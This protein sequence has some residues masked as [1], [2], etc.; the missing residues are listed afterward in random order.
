MPPPIG[1]MCRAT[2][3][4]D[5]AACMDAPL[6]D[7]AH[8][9]ATLI[10]SRR[11]VLPKRLTGPEPA[12]VEKALILQAASAAP[13]HHRLQPWRWIEVP[14]ERRADLGE[15]FAAALRLRDPGASAC[16]EAQAR[17]KALR[18]P[19]LLLTV[20]RCA[21]AG[22]DVPDTERLLSAGAAIQNML[23]QATAL[24][25]ASSITSGKALNSRPLRS[26]FDLNDQ[27]QVL[28]FINIGR[29]AEPRPMRVRPDVASFYSVLGDGALASSQHLLDHKRPP[30]TALRV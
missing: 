29:C 4:C 13:D 27:E 18:A 8:W 20:L 16:A 24:G 14:E 23:L 7:A 15:A 6:S 22:E 26:L 1:Q 2:R 9:A 21:H 10:A 28:C 11:T 30:D 17:A 19:W 25:L 12:A 3:A 5:I